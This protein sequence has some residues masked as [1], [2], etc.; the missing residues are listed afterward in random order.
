MDREKTGELTI[1]ALAKAAGVGV[2]TVRYYQRRG[3]LREPEHMRGNY[4]RYGTAELARL[5]AIRRAKQL[6]FSLDEIGALLAL[7]EDTDRERARDTAQAKIDLIDARIRQLQDMR[8]ALA[9]L[10]RCCHD[11]QPGAPCPILRALSAG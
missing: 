4:R 10:V 5:R 7:N 11:T 9:E 3:L 8:G 6:G 1:G 2:E